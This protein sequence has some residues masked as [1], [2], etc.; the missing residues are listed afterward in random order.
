[1]EV[2]VVGEV[3]VEEVAVVV[4]VAARHRV[5]VG[6]RPQQ[7]VDDGEA[8]VD[9]ADAVRRA[10]LPRPAVAPAVQR[11][12][13]RVE[14][15]RAEERRPPRVLVVLRDRVVAAVLAAQADAAVVLAAAEVVGALVVGVGGRLR[16]R[17]ALLLPRLLRAAA[18]LALVVLYLV[19]LARPRRAVARGMPCFAIAVDGHPEEAAALGRPITP[20]RMMKPSSANW[21]ASAAVN[22]WRRGSPRRRTRA[23]GVAG[24]LPPRRTGHRGAHERWGVGGGLKTGA[25]ALSNLLRWS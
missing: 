9:P 16:R 4:A 17:L 19:V 23:R 20:R 7:A 6:R 1:M 11:V 5:G 8:Q 10:V 22:G 24:A 25:E 18:L 14:P 3:M 13:H 12:E 15:R 2:V 21:A